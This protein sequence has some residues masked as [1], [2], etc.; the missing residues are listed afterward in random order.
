MSVIDP[1]IKPFYGISTGE[2]TVSALIHT[3][4]GAFAGV[5]INTDGINNATI[6]VYDNTAASGKKVHE[7]VV[8]GADIT[9]GIVKW[10]PTEVFIGLYLSISGTG[11]SAIMDYIDRTG[12]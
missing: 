8:L 11:A 4:L 7:Q 12:G 2:K 10:P 5:V 1:A 3:G 6:I 9:D